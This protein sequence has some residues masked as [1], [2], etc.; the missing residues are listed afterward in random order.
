ME[1]STTDEA[2]TAKR[3]LDNLQLFND[4]SMLNVY[5]SANERINFQNSNSGGMGD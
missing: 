4:G 5:F 1:L 2:C 3:Q